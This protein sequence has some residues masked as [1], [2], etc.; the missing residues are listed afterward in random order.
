VAST[1]VVSTVSVVLLGR[2][3]APRTQLR[4]ALGEFGALVLHEGEIA[5]ADCDALVALRPSVVLVNLDSGVEDALGELESLFDMP[6]V[7]VVFNEPE[8]SG[9]LSGW[10]LA[11]WA[12]HLASKMLGNNDTVPPPPPGAEPLAGNRFLPEPGAPPTPAQEA[13][14]VSMDRF[15]EEAAGSVFA[16][17]SSRNLMDHEPETGAP[18]PAQVQ[19]AGH[20]ATID[21]AVVQEDEAQEEEQEIVVLD[22]DSIVID[23]VRDEAV[24]SEDVEALDVTALDGLHDADSSVGEE[25]QLPDVE[26][27]E[28]LHGGEAESGDFRLDLDDIENSLTQLDSVEPDGDAGVSAND[29]ALALNLGFDLDFDQAPARRFDSDEE[30]S[31]VDLGKDDDVAALAAQLD[32]MAPGSIEDAVADPDFSMTQ[33][34]G[35]DVANDGVVA[36]AAADG[37]LGGLSLAPFDD[38]ETEEG[39]ETAPAIA[40]AASQRYDFSGLTMSL[41]PI[42]E[43]TEAPAPAVAPA[44]TAA[45][46]TSDSGL[47]LAAIEDEDEGA[48]AVAAPVERQVAS[49]ADNGL[50]LAAMDDDDSASAASVLHPE[51][52]ASSQSTVGTDDD[53][54]LL[55]DDDEVDN[56]IRRVIV[57]AASIG[58]PD[59][60]RS[61]LT[62]LPE[63][64]PALILLCQHLDNGF[65][66]RLAQQLQKVSKL[67]VRVADD[68]AGPARQGQII[69]VPSS[70]RYRFDEDGSIEAT[71]HVEPPRYQP[72][73]DDVMRDVADRFGRRV[74]GIIFSGMAGDAIEG[75]VHIT[76][77]GGEVW[78]QDPES[79]VVSSMVDGARARGVVEYVGSPRELA[80]QCV[81]RFDRRVTEE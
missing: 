37:A 39:A 78:A 42:D 71:P 17:P 45:A 69:I 1:E 7:R 29:D 23:R 54:A 77:R 21:V 24:P 40:A 48:A 14:D 8:S 30:F 66:T 47:T 50:A 11:R 43:D 61:F 51:A 67:A 62:S 16:V 32:A 20:A 5:G 33:A 73:I 70:A 49:I 13:G 64:F 72:C 18:A 57:L 55:D 58:G 12:R 76:V 52:N 25:V 68:G 10:D 79:C 26:R 59:A 74:T 22:G 27:V 46:V 15:N 34:D 81:R 75:A 28:D 6:G 36:V 63:G 35:G 4:H 2:E 53:L 44:G 31:E 19:R 9:E 41:S 60:L 65:F 38:A 56:S 80:E 3:G